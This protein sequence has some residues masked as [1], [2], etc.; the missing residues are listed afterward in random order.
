MADDSFKNIIFAFI[1]IGLF[2]MLILSAVVSVGN[3]YNKDTSQIVGGSLSLNKFNQSI[4]DVEANSKI[5][6]SRFEEK[7]VFS[8]VAGIVLIGIFG[9]AKDMFRM[10]MMPFGIVTDILSNM[11]Q[12]PTYVTGIITGLLILGFI[13]ALWR[14]L[15]IGE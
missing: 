10:V 14:L 15:K 13:F 2:G 7:S 4:S 6:K 8:A 11:L 1:L 12:V 3:N 5:L 9:I